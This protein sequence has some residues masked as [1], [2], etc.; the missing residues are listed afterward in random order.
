MVAALGPHLPMIAVALAGLMLAVAFLTWRVA[1]QSVPAAAG[2]A[3]PPAS[4]PAAVAAQPAVQGAGR[5]G[6]VVALLPAPGAG[7]PAVL[8]AL[9]G[10]GDGRAASDGGARRIPVADGAVLDFGESLL[11]AENWRERWAEAVAAASSRDGEGPFDALALAVRAGVL[12]KLWAEN[13]GAVEALGARFAAMIADAQTL[14]GLRAPVYV[15]LTGADA[16]PGLAALATAAREGREGDAPLGWSNPNPPD[17]AFDPRWAEDAAETVAE[18]LEAVALDALAGAGGD[19]FA[20]APGAALAMPGEARALAAPLRAFLAAALAPGAE[21]EEPSLRGVYWVGGADGG[22]AAFAADVVRRKMLPEAGL[23]E[24]LSRSA[25]RADMIARRLRIGAAAAAGVGVIALAALWISDNESEGVNRLLALVERTTSENRA[26]SAAGREAPAGTLERQTEQIFEAMAAVRFDRVETA[27]APTSFSSSLDRRIRSA[28]AVGFDQVA[29]RALNLGLKHRIEEAAG[30][31]ARPGGPPPETLAALGGRLV[32]IDLAVRRFGGLPRSREPDDLAQVAQAALG[33]APPPGFEDNYRLYIDALA[34]TRPQRF[35]DPAAWAALE[36]SLELPVEDAFA[37]AWRRDALF[38]ALQAV[39]REVVWLMS[40]AGA[41]PE[42][43]PVRL[44][45]LAAAIETA[46]GLLA[47]QDRNWLSGG[48]TAADQRL[49]RAAAEIGGLS[50]APPRMGDRLTVAARDGK[51]DAVS[52][53]AMMRG[54]LGRP[55]VVGVG[56]RAQLDPLY[57]ATRDTLR[58]LAADGRLLA[59]PPAS[60]VTVAEGERFGWAPDQLG[61]ALATAEALQF[62]LTLGLV[63]LPADLREVIAALGRARTEARIVG[64]IEAARRPLLAGSFGDDAA[65]A[66]AQSFAAA[67]P[68][69]GQLRDRA[70]LLLLP[71]MG[72]TLQRT[73]GAQA[74]RLLRDAERA[75]QGARPYAPLSQG[76]AFWDGRPGGAAEMFGLG[77][78][79][80]LAGLVGDWRVFVQLLGQGRAAPAIGYLRGAETGLPSDLAAAAARWREILVALADYDRSSPRNDLA[81]LER[82]ILLDLNELDAPTCA[83]RLAAVRPGASFFGARLAELKDAA[84]RRC[85]GLAADAARTAGADLGAVF[86]GTLAG[87]FPFVGAGAGAPLPDPARYRDAAD[88]ATVRRFFAANGAEIARLAAGGD[89][90]DFADFLTFDFAEGLEAVR[91]FLAGGLDGPPPPTLAFAVDVDFRTNRAREVAGDQV[92]EWTLRIGDDRLSSFEA[93]RSLIWREGDAVELTARWARN[94]PQAPDRPRRG[95]ADLGAR[96]LRLSYDGPWA[97]LALVAANAAPASE[98]ALL[99]EP[100]PNVLRIETPLIPNPETAQGEAPRLDRA[101]LFLRLDIRAVDPGGGR[102]VGP[103][104]A[105]PV[106]PAR[107][108]GG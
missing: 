59:A 18:A 64:L 94:A 65:R 41:E 108:P 34:L 3:P 8:A 70:A 98:V 79:G 10:V 21:T 88:P 81:D 77:S 67:A 1:G 60:P 80:A 97:L 91:F 89:A 9:R 35:D 43:I 44:A 90:A 53:A 42:A 26:L 68:T 38:V 36:A 72:E 107:G 93:P 47:D 28:L 86:D 32:E 40:R 58:R 102:P 17:A 37:G 16:T 104:L 30:R 106:F 92:I 31:A 99:P 83:Q 12:R 15:L 87:R 51:A 56:A 61:E 19:A 57:P 2:A 78:D 95:D 14:G 74:A 13:P 25:T 50:F 101:R 85:E 11:A 45:A 66:E 75:L 22:P 96:T 84:R 5:S 48:G 46:E 63:D 82:F 69:L 105:M 33:I 103:P 52:E 24:P 73:A 7:T 54:F 39:Q 76:F 4:A 23:A 100:R 6:A 27:L 49:A 29:L 62:A 55:I 20:A 71:R